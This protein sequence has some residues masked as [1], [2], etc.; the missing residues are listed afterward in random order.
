MLLCSFLWTK[1]LYAKDVHKEVLP[2]YG[3]KCLLHKVVHDWVEKSCEGRLEV[4]DDD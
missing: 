4:T 2:V 3:D 1:G